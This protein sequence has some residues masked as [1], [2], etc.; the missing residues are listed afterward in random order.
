MIDRV[1]QAVARM[2]PEVVR[3]RRHLHAHP[4][5]SF[6]ENN[7]MAFVAERLRAAGVVLRTGLA[8][9][10]VIAEVKGEAGSNDRVIALRGDMDALP[11]N[12]QNTFDHRSTNAGVMHACGHD[13]HMS[14]VL[15]A[16]LILQ[17]LRKEWSGTV[18]LVF[19]PGE[20]KI[21]GGAS[22]LL[23]ENAF[24][25]RLPDGI[26]AQHVTPEL[27]V[28]KVGFCEGPFMASSDE[29]YLTVKGRGG[30]AAQPEKLI[31]PIMIMARLLPQLKDEFAAVRPAEK[32]V[33]AFGRVE[34]LGATNVVPN[35]VRIAGTLRAFNETLRRELHSW[36]QKRADEICRGMGGSCDVD[37]RHGYPV[38]VNDP[39][40]TQ[41][42]RA[43]AVAFVGAENVVQMDQRMGS[44]DFAFYTHVMP[45]CLFRLGTGAP[46]AE[47]RLL[48]TPTFDIDEAALGIGCGVM[49]L[50]VLAEL[51]T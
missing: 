23:K 51:A 13:A 30:H 22:L 27:T 4:E 20:E 25:P 49:V 5:L 37:V 28:G 3:L 45:G 2:H 17:E 1:K 33:L 9:T 19:Q 41:R 32:T 47:P 18:Q 38:V 39:G 36:L 43:S 34:A 24:G 11:I 48:H 40:L 14:M 12:E 44:E 16:G 21:P 6:H 15:G 42:I 46:G 29:L 31:D 35:E 10:G 50:A 7:T 26:I 8:G